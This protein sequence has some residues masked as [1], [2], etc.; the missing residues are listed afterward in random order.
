MRI[1]GRE[2]NFV[3]EVEITLLKVHSH[4]MLSQC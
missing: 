1:W 4:L 3:G 2:Q